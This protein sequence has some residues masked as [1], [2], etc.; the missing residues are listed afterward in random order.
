LSLPAGTSHLRVYFLVAV[1]LLA[2][3]LIADFVLVQ[4]RL[5]EVR[6]L[7]NQR[8]QLMV[9]I[10]QQTQQDEEGRVLAHVLRLEDLENMLSASRESDPAVFIGQ[11]LDRTRLTSLGLTTGERSD[12]NGLRRTQVTLRVL[13]SYNRIVDFIRTLE[14]E[15]RLVA[16]DALVI[17]RLIDS[18]SLEGRLNLSI[19]DPI[20]R[21]QS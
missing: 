16:I 13:G 14:Q 2:V 19:F 8:E 1:L 21:P 20:A 12:M 10:A 6:R 15:P 3:G 7:E 4:P 11:I 18:A 5:Q 17:K 9:Q